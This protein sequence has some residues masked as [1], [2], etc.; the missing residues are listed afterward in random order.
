M[1]LPLQRLLQNNVREHMRIVENMA[2]I[3]KVATVTIVFHQD[4]EGKSV[5]YA[6]LAANSAMAK[7]RF[8]AIRWMWLL[9][10][11]EPLPQPSPASDGGS[12]A[13]SID[14]IVDMG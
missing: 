14:M 3:A 12:K 5:C 2:K 1:A 7:L 13:R 10:C 4:F 11:V 6:K 8:F 9:K